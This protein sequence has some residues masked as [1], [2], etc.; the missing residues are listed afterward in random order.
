MR[1]HKSA[2]SIGGSSS[3]RS[4]LRASNSKETSNNS[5]RAYPLNSLPLP[6]QL[7]AE[8]Q[9]PPSDHDECEPMLLSSSSSSVVTTSA[10]A[11]AGNGA[12][13]ATTLYSD[14][15]LDKEQRW[16]EDRERPS[17]HIVGPLPHQCAGHETVFRTT[18]GKICKPL[19]ETEFWFYKIC[20]REFPR[21]KPFVPA[22]HGCVL[23][24]RKKLL[25][26]INSLA[27]DDDD[28]SSSSSSGDDEPM[29][30]QAGGGVFDHH[31]HHHH[32]VDTL[33]PPVP[34]VGSPASP[35]TWSLLLSEEF[36]LKL[37]LD[38]MPSSAPSRSGPRIYPYIVLEDLTA[39]YDFPCTLDIKMGTKDLHHQI[40]TSTTLGLRIMGMQVYEPAAHTYRQFDKIQGRQLVNETV[41]YQLAQFVTQT[42]D[43]VPVLRCEVLRVFIE[44][45]KALLAVLRQETTVQIQNSSILLIYEGRVR[46]SG[47]M[48]PAK[49]DVRMIDFQHVQLSSP[50]PELRSPTVL[51]PPT[52]RR[53]RGSVSSSSSSSSAASSSSSSGD[54][55]SIGDDSEDGVGGSRPE[56]D[57]EGLVW[58]F[59][60]LISLLEAALSRAS[61]S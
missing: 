17:V 11:A 31:H 29:E 55:D 34:R 35:G 6:P 54:E 51:S 58:G 25:L 53:R 46:P 18:D 32:L 12:Y 40:S 2:S 47:A 3:N 37:E 19:D 33:R 48:L 44:K 7:A 21:Y 5:N 52:T 15:P 59:S 10:A 38:D 41:P 30:L 28:D 43:G 4:R 8:L 56:S 13:E 23:L 60:N 1:N 22:W 20:L 45:L 24:S 26:L 14:Y 16:R 61:S 39:G 36:R 9:Q 42:I 49:A 27:D 50:N 57:A